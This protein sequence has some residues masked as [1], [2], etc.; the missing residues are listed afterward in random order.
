VS[1][2]EYDQKRAERDIAEANVE[3]MQK[4]LNDTRL[5]APFSGVVAHRFV[6]NF[7]EVNAK[8]PIV[9]LQDSRY[10]E[11]VINVPENLVLTLGQNREQVTMVAAFD[12]LPGRTFPLGIKEFSTEADA[13]TQSF[14]VVMAMEAPADI[15]V[16]A[17]MTVSVQATLPAP[18]GKLSTHWIPAAA[19]FADRE[20]GQQHYVWV[21]DAPGIVSRRAVTVG[22]LRS[23]LVEITAGVSRGEHIVTAGVHSLQPGDRVRLLA[24]AGE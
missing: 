21:I 19:L 12:A 22:S 7:Q 1:R 18:T 24:A 3:R 9:S 2:S 15:E 6:E 16:F 10:L 20:G 17:G 4:A 8:Q 14:E 23:D 11:V 5:T 13:T